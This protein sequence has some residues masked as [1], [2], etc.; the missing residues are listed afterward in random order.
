MTRSVLIFRPVGYALIAFS[1]LGMVACSDKPG[2]TE[3][4]DKLH[5]DVHD[6]LE[7]PARSITPDKPTLQYPAKSE[8]KRDVERT[9]LGFIDSMRLNHCRLGQ[10]IAENNSSLGKLKDGFSKYHADLTMVEALEECIE[11]PESANVKAQLEEALAHKKSQLSASLANAFAYEEGLRKALSIGN[12][13]LP[14]IHVTE[15][16]YAVNALE[17]FTR[18]LERWNYTK[19]ADDP[20]E[21][22]KMLGRL[23]RSNYLPDLFRTMLDYAHKLDAMHAQLPEIPEFLHCPNGS[24]PKKAEQL[25]DAFNNIYIKEMQGDIAEVIEQHQRLL[26]TLENLQGIAPQ[27]ALKEYIAELGKLSKVLTDATVHFVRPWQR[28]YSTCNFTPAPD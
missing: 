12:N 27:P 15:Y 21:M 6:T 7:L 19:E 8:L 4:A 20:S 17:R 25:R 24:V 3:Y 26:M 22:I 16:N 5:S 18:I 14:Q 9:S 2:L 23:E 10:E 28:F 11:H 13:S 1:A